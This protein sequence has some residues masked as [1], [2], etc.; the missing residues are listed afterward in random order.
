MRDAKAAGMRWY[1]WGGIQAPISNLKS[2]ISNSHWSGMTR[3]KQGFGGEAVQHPPTMDLVFRPGWY[4]L[5]AWL[6][7]IRA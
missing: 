5:L 1:D 4:T 7:K 3:F 2:Q 6:A